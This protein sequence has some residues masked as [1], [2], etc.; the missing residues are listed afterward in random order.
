MIVL[1][2][3]I[4]TYFLL[5]D[6]CDAH[7]YACFLPTESFDFSTITQLFSLLCRM[8]RKAHRRLDMDNVMSQ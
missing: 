4:F 2:R 8:I 3:K 7:V 1:I 6:S 5:T